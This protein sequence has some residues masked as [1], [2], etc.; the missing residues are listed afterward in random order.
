MTHRGGIASRASRSLLASPRAD[1][2][3]PGDFP[4]SE[5]QGL[6][7]AVTMIQHG[8]RKVDSTLDLTFTNIPDSKAYRSSSTTRM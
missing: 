4:I 3:Q 5:F 6:N 1:V 2:L 8:N 7:G